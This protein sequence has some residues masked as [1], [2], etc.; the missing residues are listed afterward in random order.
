MVSVS[1]LSDDQWVDI[2][3]YAEEIKSSAVGSAINAAL[4]AVQ[5]AGLV[6]ERACLV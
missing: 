1:K 4:D 2:L 6:D 3:A 5:D